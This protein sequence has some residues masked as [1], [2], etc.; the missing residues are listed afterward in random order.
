MKMDFNGAIK[1]LQFYLDEQSFL[2]KIDTL[3]A[4]EYFDT[5]AFSLLLT[6]KNE[7]FHLPEETL[8]KKGVFFVD[9][10]WLDPNVMGMSKQKLFENGTYDVKVPGKQNIIKSTK[11]NIIKSSFELFNNLIKDKINKSGY[12]N[13]FNNCKEITYQDSILI[14]KKN[15]DSPE[16]YDIVVLRGPMKESTTV[17]PAFLNSTNLLSEFN[18]FSTPHTHPPRMEDF[19]SYRNLQNSTNLDWNMKQIR[20]YLGSIWRERTTQTLFSRLKLL[21]ESAVLLAEKNSAFNQS[22]QTT[23]DS[24]S[25]VGIPS[26][27]SIGICGGYAR[28]EY[29]SKYSDL[30]M[31]LIHEGN[32][33]QF[34]T[35]GETLDNILHFVPDLDLCKIENLKNLNFHEDSIS[36]ILRAFL[37]GDETY[38]DDN[39]RVEIDNMLNSI[40]L[41]RKTPL[42]P[43]ERKDG[44]RKFCWSIYKSI[45]NMVPIYEKPIGKGDYLRRSINNSAKK[46]LHEIIPILLRV[47]D[48]LTEEKNMLKENSPDPPRNL[49][50]LKNCQ[51][52]IRDSIFKKYS[53]LTALQDVSTILAILSGITFTSSTTDRFKIA[54]EKKF[55]I[56]E[57]GN[58]LIQGYNV[59]SKIKYRLTD[60]LP[61]EALEVV[62]DEMK[63]QIKE[64]YDNILQNLEPAQLEEGDYEPIAYPLLIFSDLHWGLNNKLARKSLAK[65]KDICQK[66]QVRS[67]IIAGDVLNID[68]VNELA[69]SDPE[70]ISLLNELSQIQ[71]SLGDQRIHIIS[72]NHDPESFYNKFREK[73]KREL[74]IHFLGNHFMD[75]NIWVEHGDLNFWNNFSPPMD[76]FISIFRSK[77]KL[78]NQKIIVGHNH[79][80]YEEVESG[81]YANGTIGKS[82]SSILVTDESIKLLKSP[83]EY[84]FDFDKISK[85]YSGI[86][87]T[88]TSINDYIQENFDLVEWDQLT[89]SLVEN[90]N[91]QKKTWIVTEKGVPTGIIPFNRVQDISNLENIKVFEV[92]FP[93]NYTFKLDQTLKEV[94][95][96]FSVTG[97]SILP[98]MNQEKQIVGTLSIFSV[99]KPEKE[100]SKTTEAEVDEKMESV[101]NFL[102]QK[103]F[104]KQ[105][106]MK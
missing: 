49:K 104:E 16:Q 57:Q 100:H 1:S 8:F 68:R 99:P 2:Q 71:N 10:D 6:Q 46:S 12:W 63:R 33:K 15:E 70:G 41:L 25:K 20:T 19:L 66:N 54:I 90:T 78:S 69:V 45:I 72:G 40:E 59:F 102:T 77:D 24:H 82:F 83:V 7:I 74:D 26:N 105:K 31:L 52:Y 87:N 65:I 91:S 84:S 75:E 4:L 30:D 22:L 80:I 56:E 62:N 73:M 28:G 81:F 94:W 88:D 106:K 17:L 51:F 89:T 86:R 9:D 14:L 23:K 95:K 37:Q 3:N 38:L 47:T 29:S 32:Q 39:Q 55:V 18:F 48:S 103:L 11:Q 79:R 34:L 58:K 43:Q 92:A 27:F 5:P 44:I 101:G 98:V 97:D 64:V 36:N 85:D 53:A 67:I 96:V 76:Q 93:I 42:P 21:I 50:N 61:F 60:D 35:V 13:L